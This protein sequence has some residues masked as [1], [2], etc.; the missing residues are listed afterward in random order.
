MSLQGSLTDGR[1]RAVPQDADGCDD[2]YDDEDD[3]YDDRPE[4]RRPSLLRRAAGA[5]GFFFL[6]LTG[7]LVLFATGWAVLVLGLPLVFQYGFLRTLYPKIY[8]LYSTI[9]LAG[10]LYP[11]Q[12]SAS[13]IS[14]TGQLLT[15]L[16]LAAGLVLI[17]QRRR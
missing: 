10:K 8:S 15:A 1:F 4:Y 9:P 6:G 2:G 7:R 16:L 17:R 5:A 11:P 13:G 3:G 12:L 14:L